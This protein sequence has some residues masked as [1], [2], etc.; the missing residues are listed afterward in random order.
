MT[1]KPRGSPM[2]P[3]A[4]HRSTVN[5]LFM[6][7]HG[8]GRTLA[9]CSTGN[10]RTKGCR[11]VEHLPVAVTLRS[12]ISTA[13]DTLL[14]SQV[15]VDTYL[16]EHATLSTRVES[17]R[18]RLTARPRASGDAIV[19]GSQ[20]SSVGNEKMRTERARLCLALHRRGGAVQDHR[21][22]TVR[23]TQIPNDVL[24]ST[25]RNHS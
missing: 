7:A 22:T 24:E 6:K 23:P 11:K 1:V 5:T 4:L 3:P 14:D 12:K 25:L 21:S 13:H 19:K 18:L 10:A 16:S 20:N 15:I 17:P 2:N 9:R 8:L